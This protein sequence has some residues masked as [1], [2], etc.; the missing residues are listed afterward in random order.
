M[1]TKNRLEWIDI[2]KGI[3]IICVVYA[4]IFSNPISNAIFIFHMPLFFF[5]GGYLMNSTPQEN[6]L[7]N[8]SRQLLLPYISYL[9]IFSAAKVINL[10]LHDSL[11]TQIAIRT[12]IN[13]IIGGRALIEVF[14]VFWFVT[15]FFFAQQMFKRIVERRTI[16]QTSIYAVL[17]LLIG[18]A[19]PMVSKKFWLPLNINVVP[20]AV[21]FFSAGYLYKKTIHSTTKKH[22][23]K[24]ASICSGL[25]LIST[26]LFGVNDL[27]MDMKSSVYGIP[28]MSEIVAL[29][30]IISIIAFAITIQRKPI[31]AKMLAI[32][33]ASSMT[34]MFAHQA[35]HI[36]FEN[37]LNKYMVFI[38]AC[39]IPLTL[40]YIFKRNKITS[41]YLLGEKEKEI[42]KPTPM[43]A[44]I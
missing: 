23:I 4:R 19:L 35:V 34:I 43:I 1:T 8:K 30:A 3:G 29:I 32:M 16:T 12:A 39:I 15:C 5:I 25:F 28:V 9:L 22:P 17:L 36:T 44:S 24:T 40:N 38:L 7:R 31:I 10:Y 26:Y 37:T 11:T 33:G 6:Y 27:R 14:G 13:M 41:K 18:I 2:T 42:T 21:F 20:V